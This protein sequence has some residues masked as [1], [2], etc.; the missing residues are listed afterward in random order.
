MMD[1]VD[2][3]SQVSLDLSIRI[4]NTKIHTYLC[5]VCSGDTINFLKGWRKRRN[6]RS[7]N[8]QNLKERSVCVV[9]N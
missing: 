2:M 3:Q 4:E 5:M 6:V 1:M 8:A 7:G 9:I